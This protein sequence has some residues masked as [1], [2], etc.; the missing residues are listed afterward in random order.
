MIIWLWVILKKAVRLL[1]PRVVWRSGSVGAAADW[2]GRRG[3]LL[4]LR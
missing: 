2:V 4:K 3:S 1:K